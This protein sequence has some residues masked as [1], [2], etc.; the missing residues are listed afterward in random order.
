MKSILV[1]FAAVG[2]LLCFNVACSSSKPPA[3]AEKHYQLVGVIKELNSKDQTATIAHQAIGDWMG[4]MTMEYPIRSKEEFDKLQVGEKI[5]ATVN[6]RGLDYDLSSVRP[7]QQ[8]VS[9]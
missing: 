5:T 6:V 9:Q 3:G 4:A 7:Q 8:P 1:F 2:W